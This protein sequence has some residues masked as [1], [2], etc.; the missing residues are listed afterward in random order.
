MLS[1]FYDNIRPS[2]QPN[3]GRSG[4]VDVSGTCTHARLGAL[5]CH[6]THARCFVCLAGVLHIDRKITSTVH[7]HPP[8]TTYVHMHLVDYTRVVMFTIDLPVMFISYLPCAEKIVPSLPCTTCLAISMHVSVASGPMNFRVSPPPS[9]L[10]AFCDMSS[11]TSRSVK[12]GV[13]EE[14]RIA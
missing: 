10:L 1:I 11:L 12:R 2:T 7:F 5:F 4:D 14:L 6:C 3:M 9:L 13:C 8:P